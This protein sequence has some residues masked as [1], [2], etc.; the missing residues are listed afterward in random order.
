MTKRT[1][2]SGELNNIRRGI[3]RCRADCWLG[4][5]LDDRWRGSLNNIRDG[6]YLLDKPTFDPDQWPY[7]PARCLCCHALG[8]FLALIGDDLGLTPRLALKP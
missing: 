7:A 5:R 3:Y 8:E 2:A 4:F 6:I 1:A